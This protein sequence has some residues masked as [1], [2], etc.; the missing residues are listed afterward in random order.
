[1]EPYELTIVGGGPVGLFAATLA[2]LHGLSVQIIESLAQLGGQMAALYP[3]KPV[4]DVPGFAGQAAARIV[5]ALVEQMMAYHPTIRLDET[6]QTV[7]EADGGWLRLETTRGQY[8]TRA[9]LVTAGLGAFTP[10]RL[11]AANADRFEGRGVYYIPPAM[12]TFAGRR[13]AVVGGGDTAIDWALSLVPFADHIVIVHRRREFRAQQ[14]SLNQLSQYAHVTMM[15]PYEVEAVLGDDAVRA[16][17]LK[18]VE[19]PDAREEWPV[20]AVIGGLGFHA[21]LGP[22]AGWGLALQGTAIVVEP[23]TM[24]TSRPGIYAAGDIATYPGKVRLVAVGFGE[25]GLAVDHIRRYVRP[26]LTGSLPHSTT[27]GPSPH[28]T[29]RETAGEPS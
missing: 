15:A 6:V 13:V 23:G 29:I 10:R 16:L 20:D 24:Q 17:R 12:A 26:H 28:A 7:A 27:L 5:E 14:A 21:R 11:T 9:V 8:L 25:V 4:Y 19:R 18:S 1:V 3:E 2:A 22:L